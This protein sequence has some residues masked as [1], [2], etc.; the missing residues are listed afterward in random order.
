[1]P[2][3]PATRRCFERLFNRPFE[4][5]EAPLKRVGG[6]S[7][8]S[9]PHSQSHGAAAVFKNAIVAFVV[10]L[11]LRGCPAAIIGLVMAL[12][13]QALH[14]V[15]GGLSWTHVRQ[16]VLK[17]HPSFANRYASFPIFGEGSVVRVLAAV[18]HAAPNAVLRCGVQ[19]V[20][21]V[22]NPLLFALCTPALR[23]A[24]GPQVGLGNFDDG[25]ANAAA[26]NAA[27]SC[28]GLRGW[29]NRQR[30]ELKANRFHTFLYAEHGLSAQ[31]SF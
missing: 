14:R 5:V 16:E 12:V 7:H 8:F 30:P 4:Q 3:A 26:Q 15:P 13:I 10:S 20:N 29:Q 28:Q 18:L 1:M 11:L 21:G 2:R 27:A 25:A 23:S 24:L 31:G 19:A 6:K 22:C 9:R 17:F